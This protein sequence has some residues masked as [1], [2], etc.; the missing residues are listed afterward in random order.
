M[1]R[2]VGVLGAKGDYEYD[3]EFQDFFPSS[4]CVFP[5]IIFN[6]WAQIPI[7]HVNRPSVVRRDT[8]FSTR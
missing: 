7:L 8:N 6:C 2:C 4:L 1:G 3:E 5:F